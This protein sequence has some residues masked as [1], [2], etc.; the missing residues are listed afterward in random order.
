MKTILLLAGQSRRF[1]PFTDKPFFTICGKPLIGHIIER[2]GE[3]GCDDIVLVGGKHNLPAA[4]THFPSHRHIEQD[5][6][7]LGMRGALLSAVPCLLED[8]DEPVLIVSANDLIDADAYRG[9][10]E[11][12]SAKGCDGAILAKTVDRYFPGG[13]LS[14]DGQRI[15]G[16]V[17]KP[18]AGNEPS[19]LVNIV[20][21]MHR[22]GQKLLAAMHD[23]RDHRDDGYEQGLQKLLSS[24]AYRAVPHRGKWQAIKYPW[25]LLT[26]LPLLLAHVAK[27][28]PSDAIIHP[29]AVI[30]G[31]VTLGKS[32][33]VLPHACVIGP[34]IIGD[35]TI[36]GNNALVRQSSIGSHCVIGYNT[37][38][39]GSILG[40]DVWTHSSYIGDS[41]VGDNVSFGAG[42]VTGN[43][44]LDEG[45][46]LSAVGGHAVGIGLTKFGVII[47]NNC[48]IGFH[49]GFNPGTKVGSGSFIAGGTIVNHDIPDRSFARVHDGVMDV[50]ENKKE[51]P[52]PDGRGEFR[53][54]I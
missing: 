51:I 30:E 52:L 12:G 15:T 45:E 17:E 42:S 49:V 40:D 44:R 46:I 21:H 26:A 13:Y 31:P 27:T 48:R 16:I 19:N 11:A 41:V 24:L 53:K 3:A 23:I 5:D 10:I 18:G 39:K 20:C 14:I 2:L 6:L 34:C 50:T 22:S 33:R 54:G 7:T 1:W 47:G 32:V 35:N 29:T 25:H 37:E 8:A 36:V 43:L 28:I 38:V 4:R 9:V